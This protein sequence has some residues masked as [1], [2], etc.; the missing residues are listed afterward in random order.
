MQ[1]VF[2][3]FM[4]R[5]FKKQRWL[6]QNSAA[7]RALLTS[8][9]VFPADSP[10][11]VL[12]RMQNVLFFQKCLSYCKYHCEYFCM[13][14]I[15]F[16]LVRSLVSDRTAL[17]PLT[18]SVNQ[19]TTAGWTPTSHPCCSLPARS[20][21]L[22]SL[23]LSGTLVSVCPDLPRAHSMPLPAGGGAASWCHSSFDLS[24]TSHFLSLFCLFMSFNVL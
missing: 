7:H 13:V 9:V 2:I 5:L 8:L 17:W 3:L 23:C 15:M 10:R 20:L 4:S 21:S 14:T 19:P 16:A 6:L 24:L 22:Q 18:V 11:E 1:R 12:C